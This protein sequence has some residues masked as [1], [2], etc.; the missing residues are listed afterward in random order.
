M[1]G[2]A[3]KA[4]IVAAV[5]SAVTVQPTL[6]APS[7]PAA[8]VPLAASA[9]ASSPASPV[10]PGADRQPLSPQHVERRYRVNGKVRVLLFWAG[11]DNV[12]AARLQWDASSEHAALT[13]LAGSNPERAPNGLNQ[14]IYLREERLADAASVFAL[15]SMTDAESAS[16]PSVAVLD[17]PQFGAS[18][19][20][21]TPIAI[22]SATTTVTATRG[23]TYAMFGNVFDRVATAHEW[24][25][26]WMARPVNSEIGFLSALERLLASSAGDPAASRLPSTA[27]VYNNVPYDLAMVR[28]E[29]L[30]PT[31]LD[32]RSYEALVSAGFAVRNRVTGNVTRFSVTWDP[33]AARCGV[34]LP[35]SIVYQPNWWLKIELRPDDE[36]DL[37]ADPAAEQST[38]ARIRHLCARATE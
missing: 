10:T 13:L 19:T 3:A 37:P 9:L 15:R 29:P 30:G 38:L 33:L 2:S 6:L 31:T 14:W 35:V 4:A 11:R 16:D 32:D 17:G 12:G 25:A 27:Y 36:A 26:K 20:A 34:A 24:K 21:V 8:L 28:R 18:C 5:I 22:H 1:V 23:L 7:D